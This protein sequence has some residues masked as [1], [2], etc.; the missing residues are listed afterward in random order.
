MNLE[1]LNYKNRVDEKIL[2]KL[3]YVE[4]PQYLYV[5]V[6]GEK[7]SLKDAKMMWGKMI[8]ECR[9]RGFNKLLVEK[10]LRTSLTTLEMYE[11]VIFLTEKHLF[12][13]KMGM[14]DRETSH[15]KTN[16][17]GELVGLNRGL[18]GRVFKDRT[19]AVKWLLA[20]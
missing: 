12:D 5:L 13:I 1:P 11:L 15:A 9:E 7:H 4:F 3:K 16:K 8:D 20:D 6:S 19:E 18:N 17:F 10:N 14:F 2:S